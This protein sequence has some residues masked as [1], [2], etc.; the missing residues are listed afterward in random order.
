LLGWLLDDTSLRIVSVLVAIALFAFL[1]GGSDAQRTIDVDVLASPGPPAGRIL[2]TPLPERV[3]VTVQGPRSLLNELPNEVEPLVVDLSR[4]PLFLDFDTVTLKLPTGVS[5]LR[6]LP[7]RL[8]LR[9]DSLTSRAMHIEPVFNSPPEG[10]TIKRITLEPVNATVT[11]PHSRL[12][13]LQRLRTAPLDLTHATV[14]AHSSKL[15]IDTASDPSLIGA[16]VDIDSVDVRYEIVPETK[17]RT[18]QGLAVLG[19]KGRG[20]TIR[21]HAVTVVVTCSPKRADE[22]TADALVPK[23]DLEA[24]G[25]DFGKKGP[26]EA[27][28]H[29][30]VPGC[31]DVTITPAKVAVTR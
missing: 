19:L 16:R 10:L 31:S 29:L 2:L 7:P 30:E 8:D 15:A 3:H 22:L 24:L 27:D 5:R 25:P 14:G 11:G 6:S 20:A 12:D 23:I 13:L 18:F 9:W 17:T 21:P 4:E 1:R 26:E 28:V